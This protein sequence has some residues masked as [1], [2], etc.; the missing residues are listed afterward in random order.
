MLILYM[1]ACHFSYPRNT[2]HICF[3]CVFSKIILGSTCI[4][5]SR[6]HALP[7]EVCRGVSFCVNISQFIYIHSVY[8]NGIRANS[9]MVD[10]NSHVYVGLISS[11][12]Y[13]FQVV[14]VYHSSS[15]SS[16]M[17]SIETGDASLF[18]VLLV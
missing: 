1:Y 5:H 14:A 13:S 11:S 15:S 12:V 17:V 4:I 2:T 6:L 10:A 18:V 3:K 7:S 9:I 8:I 16:N